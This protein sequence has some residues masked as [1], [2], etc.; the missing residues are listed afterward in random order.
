[1]LGLTTIDPK[2]VK[3]YADLENLIKKAAHQYAGEVRH[4][5]FPSKEHTSAMNPPIVRKGDAA[6][7]QIF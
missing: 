4:S 6:Y 3:K 2:L 1:M 5:E 7:C